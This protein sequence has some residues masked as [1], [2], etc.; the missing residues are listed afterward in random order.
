MFRSDAHT[1]NLG[2]PTAQPAV[3]IQYFQK[4]RRLE[5][6]MSARQHRAEH[7]IVN[8]HLCLLDDFYRKQAAPS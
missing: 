8:R 3:G 5:A 1:Q 4:E 2:G 6:T 7:S